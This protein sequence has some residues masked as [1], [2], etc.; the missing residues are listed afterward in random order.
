MSEDLPR[1]HLDILFDVARFGVR[2]A[3][4][5]LEEILAV[6]LG[7]R[8]SQWPEAFQVAPDAV[9]L[10]NSEADSNERLQKEDSVNTRDEAFLLFFP[11]D[12][13]DSDA[14]GRSIFWGDA[15]EVSM[16]CAAILTSGELNESSPGIKLFDRPSLSHSIKIAIQFQRRL[17]WVHGIWIEGLTKSRVGANS[18]R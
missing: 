3:H 7:F 8:D 15:L 18:S 10:L 9:L 14:V 13:A 1:E 17:E 2:E 11:P 16:D 6:G 5:G 4:N 12:A